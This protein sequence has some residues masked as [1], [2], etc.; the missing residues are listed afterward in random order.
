[1][2]DT[3][4]QPLA[5][6]SSSCDEKPLR[7]RLGEAVQ[8]ARACANVRFKELLEEQITMDGAFDLQSG[9]QELLSKAAHESGIDDLMGAIHAVDAAESQAHAVLDKY[10]GRAAVVELQVAESVATPFARMTEAS[11]WT[12]RADGAREI[13]TFEGAPWL[14]VAPSTLCNGHGLFAARAFARGA[15]IV[16]YEG[17]ACGGERGKASKHVFVLRS[18]TCLDGAATVA[19]ML[20][21]SRTP[22]A[23]LRESGGVYARKAI[24]EGDELTVPYGS[25]YWAVHCAD[26][27]EGAVAAHAPL[28]TA[29]QRYR[30]ELHALQYKPRHGPPGAKLDL[31]VGRRVRARFMATTLGPAGTK[32]SEGRVAAARDDGEDGERRYDVEFD[33]GDAESHVLARYIRAL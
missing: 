13:V 2:A 21:W 27:Q 1:M 7:A 22:N 32:W 14:C 9:V 24:A 28:P 19:G 16:R 17:E 11:R 18:G 15:L 31:A 20:N 3:V 30:R 10:E 29:E 26:R 4:S 33:D 5:R 25:G 12:R 6:S 23:E 8:A